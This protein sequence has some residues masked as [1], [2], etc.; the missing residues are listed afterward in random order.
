LTCLLH[1]FS[2]LNEQYRSVVRE[3][4][5]RIA[6]VRKKSDEIVRVKC[7]KEIHNDS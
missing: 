3:S 4:I 2:T 5:N 7:I 6:H 1:Y